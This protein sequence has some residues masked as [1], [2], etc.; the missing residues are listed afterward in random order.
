MAS[1]P[2]TWGL[3]RMTAGA[4]GLSTTYFAMRGFSIYD[5][6][7]AAAGL[8]FGLVE[9]G[10]AHVYEEDAMG[11]LR[12]VKKDFPDIGFTVHTLFPPLPRRVWFNPADGLTLENRRIVNGLFDAAAAVGARIVSIHPAV[13]ND[14]TVGDPITGNPNTPMTGDAKDFQ[15]GKLGFLKVLELAYERA[16]EYGVDVLI[17]NMCANFSH[18]YPSSSSEF[19]K[20]FD[21]FPGVGMLLDIGHAL[22]R[23]NLDELLGLGNHIGQVHLHDLGCVSEGKKRGHF[24]IRDEAFFE[25]LGRLP[26]LYSTTCVF[27]HGDDVTEAEVLQEKAL[28]ENFLSKIKVKGVL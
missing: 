24:P 26:N 17:E 23:E 12:R 1:T 14:V 28:F 20:I 13:F 8:G 5:S 25:P 7:A 9:L 27:E 18:I 3:C 16:R 15:D 6:V 2:V 10:A 21:I 19:L 11:A 4:I 22:H